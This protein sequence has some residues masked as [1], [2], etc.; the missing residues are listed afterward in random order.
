MKRIVI[1]CGLL[2]AGNDHLIAQGHDGNSSLCGRE[3]SSEGETSGPNGV[4]MSNRQ[5]SECSIV[6]PETLD[7]SNPELAAFLAKVK[8]DLWDSE[9]LPKDTLYRYTLNV[10]NDWDKDA[11]YNFSDWNVVHSPYT[12]M[13][14][15]FVLKLPAC[16]VAT[17]QF[18]SPWAPEER[19]SPVNVGFY[20]EDG[21][22]W[23][24]MGTGMATILTPVWF[25]YY[26]EVFKTERLPT[27]DA[28]TRTCS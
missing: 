18:L 11:D 22:G 15:G 17:I 20:D 7:S 25:Q 26:P 3:W 5:I 1:F 8:S 27:S 19:T 21:K 16:S 4:V 28:R 9:R 24:I 12:R 6:K 23:I 2:L 13:Q 10:V 14:K